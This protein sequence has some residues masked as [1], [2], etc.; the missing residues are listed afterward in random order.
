MPCSYGHDDAYELTS[1]YSLFDS[2]GNL[3]YIGKTTNLTRRYKEHATTQPWKSE[4]AF[5]RVETVYCSRCAAAIEMRRIRQ[6][7]PP[8]NIVGTSRNKAS[9]RQA[10]ATRLKPWSRNDR[11]ENPF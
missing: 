6:E 10:R 2:S 9:R 5:V 8:Y 3:L 11:F 1:I 4:I 7:Q